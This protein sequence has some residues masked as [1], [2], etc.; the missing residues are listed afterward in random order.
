VSPASDEKVFDAQTLQDNTGHN[1]VLVLHRRAYPGQEKYVHSC[2]CWKRFPNIAQFH[3]S[4][5]KAF[6]SN[7][8]NHHTKAMHSRCWNDEAIEGMADR[9][10]PVLDGFID[11]LT[12]E[13]HGVKI[14]SL[15]TYADVISVASSTAATT[16]PANNDIMLVMGTFASNLNHR[17]HLMEYSIDDAMESFVSNLRSLRADTLSPAKTAFIGKLMA[18]TYHASNMECGKPFP[19]SSSTRESLLTHFS[20]GRGSDLRR[21]DLIRDRFSSPAL[22]DEHRRECREGFK[23]IVRKLQRKMV[24]AI[25]EQGELV[26][27]DLQLLRNGHAILENEKDVG[28]KDKVRTEMR[29]VKAEVERLGRVVG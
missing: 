29:R 14:A 9:L 15:Q 20:L 26:E 27:A 3:A 17:K 8:G 1:G 16:P 13:T 7:Y 4:T 28:F 12:A 11:S 6:C 25:E 19:C 5:Y 10:H 21:K 23:R 18:D 24:D 2:S 22:F